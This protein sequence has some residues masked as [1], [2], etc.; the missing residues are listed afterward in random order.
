MTDSVAHRFMS[1]YGQS[2]KKQLGGVQKED[3][4]AI[5]T[6]YPAAGTDLGQVLGTST[7]HFDPVA[8][9]QDTENRKK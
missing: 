4:D 3:I 9:I 7:T 8:Y 6:A 1:R 2:D 5:Y